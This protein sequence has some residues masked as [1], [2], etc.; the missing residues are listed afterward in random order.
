MKINGVIKR[1]ILKNVSIFRVK[2]NKTANNL[3]EESKKIKQ[4]SKFEILE[5]SINEIFIETVG[6]LDE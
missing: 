6:D 2:D 5:P 4:L 3:F 1:T